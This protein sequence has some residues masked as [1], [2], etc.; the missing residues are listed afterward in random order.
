MASSRDWS[1]PWEVD[2]A[3]EGYFDKDL[4]EMPLTPVQVRTTAALTWVSHWKQA[5]SR[6]FEERLQDRSQQTQ[7]LQ[8]LPV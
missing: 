6:H 4:K 8:G 5:S 1:T 7:P 3:V 2:V